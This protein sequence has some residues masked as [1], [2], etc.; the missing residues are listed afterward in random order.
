MQASQEELKSTNEELQSTN[1]ELQSTNE[2]L[3]TSKEE[4]QSM[5]EEL[6]TV[7]FELKTKI[8]DFKQASNDMQNLLNSIEIATLF[9]DKEL[10]I[11]KF[12]DPLFDIMKIRN[13]DIGRP[14]TDI[15][16]DLHYPEMLNHAR[17]VLK[18]LT[19]VESQIST[20]DGRWFNIRIIPY[21]TLD[22]R[23]EGLVI[24]F[25]DITKAK[26]VEAELASV[27]NEEK[28]KRVAELIILN[29]ELI[30]KNEEN[31]GL[32]AELDKVIEILKENNLYKV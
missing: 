17:Q 5:N 9:L 11:R 26:N 10:N 19:S 30:F 3:T 15:T 27:N 13:S 22:D 12:T 14:F 4:M 16:T 6:Q 32:E 29:K 1:E 8:A 31:E 20:T 7:N 21:R 24:T 2:E 23:I 18:T 28:V 25:V